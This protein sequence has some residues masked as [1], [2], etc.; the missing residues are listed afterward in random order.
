MPIKQ[1]L[2]SKWKAAPSAQ[3]TLK[4][5]ADQNEAWKNTPRFVKMHSL[6]AQFEKLKCKVKITGTVT[7]VLMVTPTKYPFNWCLKHLG[8]VTDTSEYHGIANSIM[9]R[10][11][12]SFKLAHMWRGTNYL[13]PRGQDWDQP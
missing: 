8:W 13:T 6:A 11:D 3:D 10:T 4:R 2:A 9:M 5:I 1:I 7:P 12:G